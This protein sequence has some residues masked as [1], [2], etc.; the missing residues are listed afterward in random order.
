MKINHMKIN[1]MQIKY[2]KTKKEPNGP[3]L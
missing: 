2:V 1:R 3:L